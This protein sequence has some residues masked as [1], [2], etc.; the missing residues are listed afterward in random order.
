[1]KSHLIIAAAVAMAAIF[2]M[3]ACSLDW[4]EGS[5]GAGQE[6]G[7]DFH[8]AANLV[9]INHRCR[10]VG[11]DDSST[12][13]PTDAGTT[14]TEGPNGIEPPPPNNTPGPTD[15]S[16]TDA[17][18]PFPQ[19][20]TAG[21]RRCAS[22]DLVEECYVQDDGSTTWR[23]RQCPTD[24]VCHNGDC[25]DDSPPPPPDCCPDGCDD[26]QICHECSCVTY[27]SS[28]CAYQH[29]PCE[30]EGQISGG[31]VCSQ[32][33]EDVTP[34]CY[35][36]CTPQANNPDETC[37]GENSVCTYEEPNQA[38]G[39]CLMNCSIGD[40][41]SDDAMDCRYHGAGHDDGVCFP[42]TGTGQ[43]GDPCNPEDFFSCAGTAICAG[44]IC[45]QSCRPFD[46]DQ[47]DC[48]SGYCLPFGP[49]MGV[50]ATST[51]MDD[52]SCTAQ[53]TTC[54]DDATGCFPAPQTGELTCY[55]FCRLE[56][57]DADCAEGET[58]F[59]YDPNNP[60]LGACTAG[61]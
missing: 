41:C 21:E 29:Q 9:C 53:F 28:T 18:E 49:N 52:G 16:I 15:A 48:A 57:D 55:D 44:G 22:P 12:T 24:E 7:T 8:C 4:H 6:C 19:E 3:T 51:L 27:D 54:G 2:L 43:V 14:D 34:R 23:T 46:Q 36:L 25:V 42:S 11:T 40:Y 17:D 58:C 38:N 31:F 59:Q 47:S 60:G 56:L 35:G 1:M 30:T 33:A 20:C 10:P 45:Q 39:F 61:F 37:P 50:C 5:Q 26:D 13:D 32:F